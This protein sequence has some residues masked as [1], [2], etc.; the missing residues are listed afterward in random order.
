MFAW[1]HSQYFLRHPDFLQWHP[2][3]CLPAIGSSRASSYI[4]EQLHI[5]HTKMSSGEQISYE[6]HQGTWVEFREADSF[7]CHRHH[8]S[9]QGYRYT[10]LGWARCSIY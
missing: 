9:A 7:T 5:N 8:P 10:G 6:I 2:L 3:L 4:C 1:K